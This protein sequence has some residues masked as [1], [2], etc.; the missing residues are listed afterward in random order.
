MQKLAKAL[1]QSRLIKKKTTVPEEIKATDEKIG[2]FFGLKE[3][4]SVKESAR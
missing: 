3:T 2:F 1:T 4:D